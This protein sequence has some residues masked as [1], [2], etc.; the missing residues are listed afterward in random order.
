V[1][2]GARGDKMMDKIF[3]YGVVVVVVVSVQDKFRYVA[4][5]VLELIL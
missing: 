2:L 4:L 5:S 1:C 3:S